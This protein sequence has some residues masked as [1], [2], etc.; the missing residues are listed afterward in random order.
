MIVRVAL[1]TSNL[2]CNT[3]ELIGPPSKQIGLLKDLQVTSLDPLVSSFDV[4]VIYLDSMV[5]SLSIKVS[6][7]GPKVTSLGAQ[8]TSLGSNVTYAPSDFYYVRQ[9][10][11]VCKLLGSWVIPLKRILSMLAYVALFLLK[12]FNHK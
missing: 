3:N 9:L 5:T 2:I 7:L 1:P 11:S 6:S 12:Y 10:P 8:V 4:Q